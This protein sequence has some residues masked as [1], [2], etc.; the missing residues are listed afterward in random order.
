[1]NNVAIRLM[2][3]HRLMKNLWLL[4]KSINETIRAWVAVE[5]NI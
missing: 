2:W 5:R 1:M 4:R 3:T